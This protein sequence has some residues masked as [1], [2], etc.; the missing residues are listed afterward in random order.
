MQTSSRWFGC[1]VT[2]RAEGWEDTSFPAP[3]IKSE[4][5][6]VRVLAWMSRLSPA[7]RCH[8]SRMLGNRERTFGKVDSIHVRN[9]LTACEARRGKSVRRMRAALASDSPRDRSIASPITSCDSLDDE[10][11]GSRTC[12]D[13]STSL[14]SHPHVPS[15]PDL[16]VAR[17]IHRHRRNIRFIHRAHQSLAAQARRDPLRIADEFAP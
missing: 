11:A 5:G 6:I 7:E 8:F 3:F 15:L 17:G 1:L 14:L 4:K 13:G 16:E 12:F 2:R 9:F 10:R